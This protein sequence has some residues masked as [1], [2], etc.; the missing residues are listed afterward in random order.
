MGRIPICKC[1]Y[2]SLWYGNTYGSGNSQHL[3]DWY[4][5]SHL[6]HG[7][8]FYGI[9]WLVARRLPVKTRLILAILIECIWEIAEN[10]PVVIERYRAITSALDYTG[11]SVINSISDV[12]A[13]ASGFWLTSKI[14]VRLTLA[15]VATLEI[16]TLYTVRDNLTLNIIMLTYPVEAIKTWQ[17]DASFVPPNLKK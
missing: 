14:R 13:A 6:I 10:S 15:L 1:G 7:M 8:I 3:I 4:T 16:F 2:I 5:F 12:L 17:L 11:D 9:L